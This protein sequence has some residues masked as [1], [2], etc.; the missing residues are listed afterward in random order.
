VTALL[1]PGLV[2]AVASMTAAM[3]HRWLR[4]STAA[5]VLALVS[6]A[7]ALAVVWSLVLLAVGF[8]AH[9][10]WLAN[11][12]A[13]CRTIDVAHVAVPPAAGL[14]SIGLLATMGCSMLRTGLRRGRPQG[15]PAATTEL[16]VLPIDEPTAYAV[17]GR[18]GHI[19]VSRGMLRALDDDER[20]VLLAHERAHLR[21]RHHQY[22]RLV[23]VAVAV[24][25]LLSPMA[26]RVRFATERWADE[27]AASQIGDRHLV[28][29]AVAQAALVTSGYPTP[30]LAFGGLGVPARVEALI[31]NEPP[32]GAATGAVVAITAIA[33]LA[34]GGST[35]QF[36]HLLAYAS[37]VCSI[38]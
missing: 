27:E 1:L 8:L 24:V 7:T 15:R 2:A 26:T 31:G 9:V 13:W 5:P 12:A 17:P 3:V 18:P 11:V 35:I 6:V 20:R 38:G 14:M 30:S 25:P 19:V 22:L 23:D 36:H 33:V 28:A 32:R 34:V 29:R 4:P 16:V 37:T 10:A 21:L